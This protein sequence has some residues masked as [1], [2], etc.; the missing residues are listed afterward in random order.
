MD[1][2]LTQGGVISLGDMS[3]MTKGR[4]VSARE[5][6]AAVN[7]AVSAIDAAAAP[8]D[9]MD[10]NAQKDVLERTLEVVRLLAPDRHLKYEV[11]DEVDMVQVQVVNTNDGNIVRKIPAD[12]I[13]ALVKHIHKTLSDRLDVKA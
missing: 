9:E 6:D 8:V 12:D 4:T 7:A 3:P 10:K 13:I 2:R 11:I 5:Q 1:V